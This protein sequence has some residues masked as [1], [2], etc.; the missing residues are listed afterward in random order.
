MCCPFLN[1]DFYP[2][3]GVWMVQVDMCGFQEFELQLV[4][5]QRST[6]PLSVLSSYQLRST[7]LTGGV[8][9]PGGIY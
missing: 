1:C 3:L 2:F 9:T 6:L 4:V 8:M 5:F 7:I